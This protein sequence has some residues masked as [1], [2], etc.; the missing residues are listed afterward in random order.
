MK[1]VNTKTG[2]DLIT[3]KYPV[4][5]PSVKEVPA[6]DNSNTPNVVVVPEFS[7]P[8]YIEGKGLKVVRPP[9]NAIDANKFGY[10]SN[11]ITTRTIFDLEWFDLRK[12]TESEWKSISSS[13]TDID[14]SVV[15][16]PYDAFKNIKHYVIF[17]Y[18]NTNK[19]N[20]RGL[21]PKSR[22]SIKWNILGTSQ[23]NGMRVFVDKGT[24]VGFWLG[25]KI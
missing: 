24:Y 2:S 14:G 11:P 1:T 10:A 9:L 16:I 4:L 21:I 25:F 17:A 5:E 15:K 18:T 22:Y 19:I 8:N 7:Y 20:P 6:V 23:G 13:F 3:W 12:L